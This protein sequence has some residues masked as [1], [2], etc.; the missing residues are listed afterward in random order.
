MICSEINANTRVRYY[1]ITNNGKQKRLIADW[2]GHDNKRI[3]TERAQSM[4][5][6][7]RLKY[8]SAKI[9]CYK[10]EK[11]GSEKLIFKTCSGPQSQGMQAAI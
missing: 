5:I 3:L 7:L 2:H 1:A 4:A 11:D 6:C 10:V 8:S 9:V